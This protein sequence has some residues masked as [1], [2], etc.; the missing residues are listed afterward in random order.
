MLFHE[1]K[2]TIT[3]RHFMDIILQGLTSE[4]RD[5]KLMTRKDSEF[6]LP[7]IQPVPRHLCLDE[8]SRSNKSSLVVAFSA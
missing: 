1:M 3:Y 8:L 5:V 4:Y 7:K 2:E 6:D